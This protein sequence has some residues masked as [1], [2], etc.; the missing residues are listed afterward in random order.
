MC[1][2]NIFL[3]KERQH[4]EGGLRLVVRASG[5]PCMLKVLA[6]K[7]K[8][9]MESKQ[10]SPSFLLSALFFSPFLFSIGNQFSHPGWSLY[11]SKQ[12]ITNLHNQGVFLEKKKKGG[13]R[14]KKK[15]SGRK[16]IKN[17]IKD[18]CV[19][20]IGM[21]FINWRW[22][23]FGEWGRDGAIFN[24]SPLLNRYH[25]PSWINILFFFQFSFF[26]FTHKH[27][28]L[29]S[30]PPGNCQCFIWCYPPPP[31]PLFFIAVLFV[32]YLFVF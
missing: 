29:T 19:W 3:Q 14:W 23:Q 9:E 20:L 28:D 25:G 4:S 31:Q 6:C 12:I 26:L 15:K 16:G 13:G 8:N 27:E 30:G 32:M 10:V 18:F 1:S 24:F 11:T 5:L 22:V 17:S 21:I 7:R 2:K